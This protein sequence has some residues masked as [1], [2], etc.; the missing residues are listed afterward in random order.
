MHTH[1]DHN[2]QCA[3]Q[4]TARPFRGVASHIGGGF[5]ALQQQD[6]LMSFC[7]LAHELKQ[8]LAAILSNA[9]ATRRFLA[10]DDPDLSEAGAAL[11]D[12]I[13]DTRRTVE[14]IQRLQAFVTTGALELTRLD[15]NA[16]VREVI[17]LVHNDAAARHLDLNQELAADLP[18]V[19][20]DRVELRQVLLNLLRNA[21]EAMQEQDGT[22]RS[23]TVRTTCETPDVV[24]VAVQDS[25]MGLDEVS[26]TRLFHPFFTTKTGGMGLGL[27]FS[28]NII[29]AHG[30][31][32][33]A[34]RN[35]QGGLTVSFTLPAV[36]VQC[37]QRLKR[38]AG[39][40]G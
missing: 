16:V 36:R 31:W 3:A 25:G 27:A 12:I 34:T 37:R 21:F 24:T 35:A 28:R 20:G 7:A 38:P 11:E 1:V 2:C 32:I 18:M 9:Q 33:W 22:A 39:R 8:P 40:C 17:Q 4:S 5:L 26:M 30:G 19:M 13:A 15:I 14:V 6:G 10:M 23:L 29:A